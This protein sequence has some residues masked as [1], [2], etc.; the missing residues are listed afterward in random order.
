[1][2]KLRCWRVLRIC[3]WTCCNLKCLSSPGNC[4]HLKVQERIMTIEAVYSQLLP[5]GN[6]GT[7]PWE[8]VDLDFNGQRPSLG[9]VLSSETCPVGSR[10]KAALAGAKEGL[11]G[12][13]VY[14]CN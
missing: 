13:T 14:L 6:L 5:C 1:M 8:A 10:E 7:S 11:H 12:A 4:C 9:R 3:T 2:V